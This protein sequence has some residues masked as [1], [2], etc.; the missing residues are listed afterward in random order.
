MRVIFLTYF[1]E[2]LIMVIDKRFYRGIDVFQYE[3]SF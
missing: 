1:A 3:A 2:Y